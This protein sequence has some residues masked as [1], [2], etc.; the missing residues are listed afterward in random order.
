MPLDADDWFVVEL[1][2]LDAAVVVTPDDSDTFAQLVDGLMV[3]AVNFERRPVGGCHR[4]VCV[5]TDGVHFRACRAV[6]SGVLG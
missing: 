2:G 1:D 6:E 5:E 4:R 3:E